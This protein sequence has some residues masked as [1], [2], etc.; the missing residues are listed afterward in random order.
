MSFK[1][2]QNLRF[3]E[4]VSIR[5]HQHVIVGVDFRKLL[6]VV[7]PESSIETFAMSVAHFLCCHI[8]GF[9]MT[10]HVIYHIADTDGC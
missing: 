10:R 7:L 2:L 1:I 8:P 9:Q 4:R 6:Q 5:S 3:G